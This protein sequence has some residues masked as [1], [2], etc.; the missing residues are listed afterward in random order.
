MNDHLTSSPQVP[1]RHVVRLPGFTADVEVGLG[2]VIKRATT[3]AGIKP[4]GGC[5]GRARAANRWL[6]FTGR[7]SS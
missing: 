6:A 1:A 3:S 2:D 5:E 7:R 4:C